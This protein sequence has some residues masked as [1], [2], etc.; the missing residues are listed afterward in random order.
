MDVDARIQLFDLKTKYQFQTQPGVDQYNMPLYNLQGGGTNTQ[1]QI[2]Y[3]PVYQGF[4]SPCYINGIQV[5]IQTEKNTFFNIWPD[6]VQ[7]LPVIAIGNG[8]AGPYNFQFPI[9]ANFNTPPNP[10]TNGILRGHVD[11]TGIVD[12]A[13][14]TGTLQDPPIVTNF[15]TSIPTTSV[16]VRVWITSIGADGSNVVVTDSGQFLQ[17]AV[18]NGLLMQPGQPPFGNQGLTGGYQPTYTI[19]GATQATQCVLT[20]TTTFQAGQNV[21]INNVVGMTQL[22]GNTYTVVANGGTTLTINVNSTSFTAY[23]SGGTVSSIQNVVNYLSGEVVN[24]YFPTAIPS[25]NNI[26]AQCYFFQSGLPRGILYYNNSITLR[27]PPDQQ[28]LVELTAYLTPCAYLNTGAAIQ[29]AYMAEYIARG[30]AR[31]ILADVGDVEQFQ[32]YEPFFK[33]QE[34]LV[35]KR[36]QRQFTATRTGT[37]YSEGISQ[38]QQGFSGLGG[39]TI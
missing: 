3:Y 21:T 9:V 37:I 4:L 16:D 32:F 34:T 20:A 10:P 15:N 8:T 30:A 12:Y 36:S 19:T 33:E 23:S 1:S 13:T 31:K 27:S 5:P 28:Y 2:N 14:A 29:F 24:L 18:N 25:G 39:S 26:N 35:W 11:M 6:I 17:G 22:N 38:G 7:Q